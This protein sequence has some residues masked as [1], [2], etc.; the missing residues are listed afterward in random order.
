MSA[1]SGFFFFKKSLEDASRQTHRC[2][3]RKDKEKDPVPPLSLCMLH[4]ACKKKLACYFPFG[5]CERF[6][7][8][9]SV[10]LVCCLFV[11]LLLIELSF[12]LIRGFA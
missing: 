7:V 8:C 3:Q 4:L 5:V 9:F 1:R 10:V 2:N 6:L 11:Q 12:F